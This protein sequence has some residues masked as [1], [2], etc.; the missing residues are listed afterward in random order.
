MRILFFVL[1]G[2]FLATANAAGLPASVVQ[3][4]RVAGVPQDA[5]GVMVQQV[6]GNK[7][8]VLHNASLAMN[9]AS[10]M[11]LLTT[12]AALELLGPAYTWHTDVMAA[13]PGKDGVLDGDLILKGSGD[14]ALTLERFWALLHT[15]RQ[16]G[17]R[18]IRGDLVLDRSV[19]EP[20][21][22]DPG[23][24]DGQPD[25]AYNVV[26]DALLVNFKATRFNFMPNGSNI[27]IIADPALPQVEIINRIQ[28][29]PAVCEDWKE[30]LTRTIQRD[31]E[32]V[33]LTFGGHYPLSCGEKAL[34]LSVLDNNS[35]VVQL[36]QQY[37]RELGGT[38]NGTVKLG[39][40]PANAQL[41]AQSVSLPLSDAVRM[42]NKNS[43]NVM[44]RQLL[45]TLGAEQGGAPGNVQKGVE[46]IHRWLS[47]RGGDFSELIMENGAGLSRNERISPQHLGEL[48]LRSWRSPT[49]P[50]LMSSLPIAG[51]DGTMQRRLNDRA[52]AGQAHIK[53]GS[54][55]GVKSMAGYVLDA[56]GRRWVVVF[57]VN[58]PKA[59]AARDA[60]DALLEW[61]Y[62]R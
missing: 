46:A 55:D 31:G 57:V 56:K 58:H 28:S 25:R 59:A 50:E 16:Q 37:W 6:D 26:P 1:G 4:L 8:L 3:A 33:I 38:F 14:P 60:M 39:V 11:K 42:I 24:F 9:P 12:S 36:F 15:L 7:P 34:E 47:A 5:V 18:E 48:L 30:H 10:T 21:P 22:A 19:F 61:V 17:L 62:A 43:N 53:T 51:V 13:T 35:Y 45:L 52:V 29:S 44:A 54:L 41:L 32:R 20:L 49:M 27:Q 40:A 2:L 23:G